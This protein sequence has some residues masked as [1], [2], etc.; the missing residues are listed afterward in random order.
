MRVVHNYAAT[1]EVVRQ[2]ADTQ[3]FL[4]FP[5][6]NVPALDHDRLGKFLEE[7]CWMGAELR[8]A[9]AVPCAVLACATRKPARPREVPCAVLACATRKPARPREVPCAVLACATRKPARPRE[10]P[11]GVSSKGFVKPVLN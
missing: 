4:V 10:V 7:R 11:A 2:G 9:T 5:S 6:G 1:S 3:R 8:V